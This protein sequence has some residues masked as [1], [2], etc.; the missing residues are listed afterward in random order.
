MNI[1]N[2]NNRRDALCWSQGR[3]MGYPACSQAS[4]RTSC[5][6]P[7]WGGRVIIRTI[8][9]NWEKLCNCWFEFATVRRQ[10]GGNVHL[11]CGFGFR[12]SHL[13][14]EWKSGQGKVRFH[15]A[16]VICTFHWSESLAKVRS[17]FTGQQ[18]YVHFMP[19]SAHWNHK[20][21]WSISI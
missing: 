14:L 4:A 18:S 12:W 15:W 3:R 8:N 13:S 19:I 1:F 21:N 9:E 11:R 16:A 6:I 2:I 20:K 5:L 17:D 7:I 10:I